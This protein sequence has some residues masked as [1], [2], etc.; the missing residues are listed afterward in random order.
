MIT[1]IIITLLILLVG[2]IVLTVFQIVFTRSITNKIKSASP[3][4]E[5]ELPIPNVYVHTL[6]IDNDLSRAFN[7]TSVV[8]SVKE[9]YFLKNNTK[10]MH[11][12][13]HYSYNG[14]PSVVRILKTELY[15]AVHI[16]VSGNSSL[17]E[18]LFNNDYMYAVFG[19]TMFYVH[20]DKE[21]NLNNIMKI[22]DI[23]PDSTITHKM[24]VL[25]LY[26]IN[27]ANTETR[28]DY[29]IRDAAVL[30]TGTFSPVRHVP[31]TSSVDS[32][33]VNIDASITDI[34]GTSTAPGRNTVSTIFFIRL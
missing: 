4:A 29:S 12:P 26:N 23:I 9:D 24:Y 27:I 33:N 22:R 5:V 8:H 3:Y 20:F 1:I 2:L 17:I 19:T 14:N 34:I 18:G 10:T 30:S 7:D 32:Q 31:F 13:F 15:N 25:S 16:V 28:I 11:H 6:M 21:W